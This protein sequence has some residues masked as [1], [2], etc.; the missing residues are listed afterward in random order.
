MNFIFINESNILPE[1]L[2]GLIN[3]TG[4]LSHDLR[5]SA[6]DES[7]LPF[8]IEDTILTV[9]SHDTE[10]AKLHHN[11]PQHPGDMDNM[12][13]KMDNLE[14]MYDEIMKVLGVDRE[15][16]TTVM[17]RLP[18]RRWSI[19][20]SDTSSLQRPVKKGRGSST[21]TNMGG[22]HRHHYSHRDIK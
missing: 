8:D 2:H 15:T 10:P 20:S 6:G 4:G 14:G 19:G 21:T 9:E 3:I 7:D 17:N 1:C 22:H 16:V 12:K 5:E 13:N 11:L 18:R